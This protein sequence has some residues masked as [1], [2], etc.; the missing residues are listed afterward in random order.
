ME[1]IVA[2][3]KHGIIGRNNK[4]IWNIPEDMRHFRRL[5]IDNIVVMGRKT[6]ESLPVDGLS[7]R[8]NIVITRTPEKKRSV[9]E[10]VIFCT[11][12][13]STEI[14]KKVSLKSEKKVFIIGGSL[15]YDIFY[16]RCERIHVTMV[17]NE[18]TEGVSIYPLLC[19]IQEKYNVKSVKSQYENVCEEYEFQT[20]E[21]KNM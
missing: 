18:V 11:L 5:T 2:V 4:M 1:M 19:E 9:N 21:K 8:I 10:S 17:E 16:K 7:R 3:N 6:Y 13:E 15:I 12:E 14:L 20:Y